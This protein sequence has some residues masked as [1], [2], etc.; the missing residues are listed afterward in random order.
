MAPRF[1]RPGT[2]RVVPF[3]QEHV[4]VERLE[5]EGPPEARAPAPSMSILSSDTGSIPTAAKKS[6]VGTGIV[7]LS[8]RLTSEDE[9]SASVRIA[10][11]AEVGVAAFTRVTREVNPLS[12]MC[13]SKS[14]VKEGCGSYASTRLSR[15]R[16]AKYKLLY[17]TFA[18]TST[19]R[20]PRPAPHPAAGS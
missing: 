1:V 7:P 18:P 6:T 10:V 15:N 8:G 11:P 2:G 20:L 17:P 5:F 16:P 12:A 19:M 9:S 3:E 4:H 13:R 14:G